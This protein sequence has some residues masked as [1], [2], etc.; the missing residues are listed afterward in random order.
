MVVGAS[1]R[2]PS[3]S[4]SSA[5]PSCSAASTARQ[6]P[7]PVPYPVACSPQAWAAGAPFLFLADDA[8]APGARRAK[9]ARAAPAEPARLARQ[10]HAHEPPRRR[11]RGRPAVPSLAGDD[12]RRGPA[13]GRRPLRH[14]PA[15]TGPRGER[16]RPSRTHVRSGTERLRAAGSESARLD[17]ELLLAHAIGTDR[18]VIVAHPEAPVG[19]GA[20][21]RFEADLTRRAAGE[22]VAYIRGIKEF[23]GLAFAVDARALIPR[24]ETERLVELAVA[25]RHGAPRRRA[26]AGTARRRSRY[27]RRRARAA[28]RSPSASRSALRRRGIEDDVEVVGDRRLA[29]GA[30][31]LARENAVGSRRRRTRCGSSRPTCC[32]RSSRRR[33]STSSLA[34]LPYVPIR[35]DRRAAR[36]GIVRAPRR[37]RWRPRR[38]GAHRPAVRRGCRRRSRQTASRCSRSGPTRRPAWPSSSAAICPA[39]RVRSSST[40]AAIREWPGSPGPE[41]WQ[42]GWSSDGTAGRRAAAAT[43]RDGGVVA[44]PTD[45]VYGIAVALG[46]AGGVERL[47]EVKARPPDKAVMVLVDA[48]D[49]LAGWVELSASARARCRAVARRPDAGAAASLR[50]A[51]A[52]RLD[53]RDADAR[54]AHPEARCAPLAGPRRRS[55]SDDLGQPIRGPGG[56]FGP[57]GRWR[58]WATAST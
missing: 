35:G 8:R 9:R 37:A 57:G 13:Q 36:R 43:L 21:E 25:A 47:F 22:P 38:A 50:S 41:P 4:P 26:R 31:A 39:G 30:L 44:I 6:S 48:L 33:R 46:T 2:P 45:T 19:D 1:S 3:S 55:H 24:P 34:N 18:T 15:L 10:G 17:A 52:R 53:G 28:A 11:R 23:Y 40:W 58:R 54:R 49:Q 29:R 5:C 20:A 51:A 14:D 7:Q 16:W 56:P 32:R 42:H 27:G 12:E